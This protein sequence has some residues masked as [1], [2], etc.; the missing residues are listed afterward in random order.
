MKLTLLNKVREK[1]PESFCLD[2]KQ[3][4]GWDSF[5]FYKYLFG[6]GVILLTNKQTNR[7]GWKHDLLGG[8]NCKLK[9]WNKY[10][11][12]LHPNKSSVKE[13]ITVIL[14][15]SSL[16]CW[17]YSFSI[18]GHI[19]RL[20]ASAEQKRLTM[21]ENGPRQR[22]YRC[23][24]MPVARQGKDWKKSEMGMQERNWESLGNV[25]NDGLNRAKEWE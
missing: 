25:E 19:S 16:K 14:L 11:T 5:K 6:F 17:Q 13:K 1:N 24:S 4:L 2:Q 7:C 21:F 12:F 8:L 20:T 15:R 10:T 23:D 3:I 22:D 9:Y 18:L